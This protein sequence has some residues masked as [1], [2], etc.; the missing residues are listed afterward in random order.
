MSSISKVSICNDFFE[1]QLMYFYLLFVTCF[2]KFLYLFAAVVAGE[3]SELL[4]GIKNDGNA[5]SM[6]DFLKWLY[7][8][9]C[10]YIL[11]SFLKFEC[12]CLVYRFVLV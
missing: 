7:G 12:S 1:E 3:E 6:H 2:L 8:V 9:C 10:V 11:P 4:A 5:L